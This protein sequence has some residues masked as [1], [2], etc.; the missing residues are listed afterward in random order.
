[1]RIS[2]WVLPILV[3]TIGLALRAVEVVSGNYV[4]GFDQGWNYLLTRDIVEEGKQRLI[5]A[6]TSGF[7]GLFH[8]PGYYYLLAI[9][10]ILFRGDPYGGMVLMF[11]AGALSLVLAYVFGTYLFGF[12][13]GTLFLFLFSVSQ[14]FI[15]QSRLLWPPNPATPLLLLSLYLY[16]RA[17]REEKS[18]LI[19]WSLFCAALLYNFHLAL[20]VPLVVTIIVGIFLWVRKDRRSVLG[21]SAV[22]LAAGYLPAILFEMR[23]GFPTVRNLLAYGQ[24]DGVSDR[25]YSF[26]AHFL[27][28]WSNYVSSFR[29]YPVFPAAWM[30]AVFLL[31]GVLILTANRR[32]LTAGTRKILSFFLLLIVITWGIFLFLNNTVWDYYLVPVQVAYLT[33]SVFA[34]REAFSRR[35]RLHAVIRA[36]FCMYVVDFLYADS[37]GQPFNVIAF[38]PP[39]YTYRYDYIFLWYG[40]NRYGFV[41]GNVRERTVY[42]LIEPD[43]TRPWSYK[44]WLET[45]IKDEGKIV[46]TTS[47]QNG[48]IVQKRIFP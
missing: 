18:H 16:V 1:M 45:V 35:D 46:Y 31:S 33:L 21:Q 47:L 14:P 2:R 43:T 34:V 7:G 26:S 3:G 17:I 20:S 6:A 25:V 36:V 32:R 11:V 10:Y 22:A 19:P 28:Y 38:T 39:V 48:F 5:G 12:V 23:H 40:K 30:Q 15:A 13:G 9:P 24:T 44:G 42:L 41:P 29:F 27:E 8:G 37:A 4:F